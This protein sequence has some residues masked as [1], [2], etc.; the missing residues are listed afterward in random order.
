MAFNGVENS[1]SDIASGESW[2]FIGHGWACSNNQLPFSLL[3]VGT[4]S[5]RNKLLLSLTECWSTFQMTPLI[6][7]TQFLLQAEENLL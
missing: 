1:C 7:S 6:A 3:N 2:D 4:V 5:E